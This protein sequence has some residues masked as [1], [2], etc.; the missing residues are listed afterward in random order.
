MSK[1]IPNEAV[2]NFKSP[3]DHGS[4]PSYCCAYVRRLY[5]TGIGLTAGFIGSHTV[6]HNYRVYTL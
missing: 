5:K 3:L 6:T 1:F 2:C 4:Y